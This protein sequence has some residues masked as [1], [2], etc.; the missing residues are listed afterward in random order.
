[1]LWY[2]HTETDTARVFAF[3]VQLTVLMPDVEMM[4]FSILKAPITDVCF[5]RIRK[6]TQKSTNGSMWALGKGEEQW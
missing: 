4:N 3:A 6:F 2:E 1:M 5:S